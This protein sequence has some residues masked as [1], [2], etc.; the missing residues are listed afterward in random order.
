MVTRYLC[1]G[2]W[3]QELTTG[4]WY[5]GNQSLPALRSWSKLEPLYGYNII[6]LSVK[7]CMSWGKKLLV[8]LLKI[9]ALKIHSS[10]YILT[11]EN[12]LT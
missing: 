5:P 9:K 4:V 6:A 10:E 8:L 12:R 3:R 11:D 2:L 7:A 1:F